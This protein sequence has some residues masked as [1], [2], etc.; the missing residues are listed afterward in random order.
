MP[1]GGGKSLTFQLPAMI[2]KGLTMVVSPLISL[3]QDQ[4]MG[5]EQLGIS[6]R[7]FSSQTTAEETKLLYQEMIDPTASLRILYVTPEKLAKSKRLMSQLEKAYE[8]RLLV[9]IVIDEVHAASQWGHD[10]RKD[11]KFLSIMKTQFPDT[12]I[13]GLTATATSKVITDIQKILNLEGCLVLKDSFFRANLVYEVHDSSKKDNVEE[14]VSI[15]NTRFLNQ[16]GIIYC[17]SVKDT[18][19]VSSKLREAGVKAKCYHAQLLPEQR[20]EVHNDWYSGKVRVIVATVAFGMGINKMDVRFV[21]HYSLSKTLEN[22]YQE[23]GRAGRDGN[24]AHCIAF[25]RFSDFQRA[26]S[27]FFTERDALVNVYRMISYCIDRE[28]CRKALIAEHFGDG[29]PDCDKMC[30]NCRNKGKISFKQVNIKPLLDDIMKVLKKA[31]SM[32]ERMT[33]KNNFSLTC[34]V[35]NK[36]MCRFKADGRDV[37]ERK[38]PLR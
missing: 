19:E 20:T 28:R 30:D 3:M 13:L 35:V 8:K 36:F 22:Y 17:L 37:L 11:Y 31:A 12:P 32:K 27:M 2:N 16:S 7:I 6:T 14:I 38:G 21:I 34:I 29:R 5:L 18:E 24:T 25:Y 10:F 33:G 15:L 9:R 1:T 23:T 26:T 4:L